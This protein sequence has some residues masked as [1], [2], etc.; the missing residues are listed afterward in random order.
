MYIYDFSN[1]R[2]KCI[3]LTFTSNLHNHLTQKFKQYD[4]IDDPNDKL[5][6]QILYSVM[7]AFKIL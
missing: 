1:L 6:I 7:H 3:T 5:L 4:V 2:V